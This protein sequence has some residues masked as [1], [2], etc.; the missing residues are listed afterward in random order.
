MKKD[1]KKEEVGT[2]AEASREMLKA[3]FDDIKKF[4]KFEDFLVSVQAM[5]GKKNSMVVYDYP[6]EDMQKYE[7]KYISKYTSGSLNDTFVFSD[8]AKRYRKDENDRKKP[9]GTFMPRDFFVHILNRIKF[10]TK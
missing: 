5:G 4:K 6:L 1:S 9:T 7:S 8:K 3:I 2:G 10:Q